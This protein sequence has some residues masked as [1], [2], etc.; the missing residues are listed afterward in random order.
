MI[1]PSLKVADLESNTVR[2]LRNMMVMIEDLREAKEI[3][4]EIGQEEIEMISSATTVIKEDTIKETAN[5][6][7]EIEG[8]PEI[9]QEAVEE[10]VT[11]GEEEDLILDRLKEEIDETEE[12]IEEKEDPQIDQEL[13]HQEIDPQEIEGIETIE[14]NPVIREV[15]TQEIE[16]LMIEEIEEADTMMM[17]LMPPS[18][19]KEEVIRTKRSREEMTIVITLREVIEMINLMDIETMLILKMLIKSAEMETRVQEMKELT[20][21]MS[22]QEPR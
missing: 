21:I 8:A 5:L 11:V 18:P 4:E 16:D 13:D 6:V 20:A 15:T 22:N 12:M 19:R 3:V 17:P 9:D 14:I 7:E 10:G 2:I 1:K